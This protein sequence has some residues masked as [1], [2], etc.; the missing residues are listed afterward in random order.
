MERIQQKLFFPQYCYFEIPEN[1]KTFVFRYNCS[2]KSLAT[3]I[4][5][6]LALQAIF[7]TT[8]LPD[9][10]QKPHITVPGRLL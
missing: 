9:S 6:T 3:E 1:A 4:L 2:L 10:F 5:T 8:S 7:V